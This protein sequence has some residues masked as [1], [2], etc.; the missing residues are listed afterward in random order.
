M[1]RA[2]KS[3]LEEKVLEKMLSHLDVSIAQEIISLWKEYKE[4]KTPEAVFVNDIDN[5]ER[6]MQAIDYHNKGN[7][8]KP[9]HGFWEKW[10]I[11][12]IHNKN[13]K[14]LI[15]DIISKGQ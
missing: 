5:A 9:L 15:M 14:N 11:N 7:Y 8:D 12:K 3:E 10:D 13:I 6:I 1:T 4:G 2:E